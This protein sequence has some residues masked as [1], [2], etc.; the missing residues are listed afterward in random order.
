MRLVWIHPISTE[1]IGKIVARKINLKDCQQDEIMSKRPQRP[2]KQLGEQWSSV[3]HGIFGRSRC[4]VRNIKK[5]LGLAQQGTWR[6]SD[7]SCKNSKLPCCSVILAHSIRILHCI[8]WINR[9]MGLASYDEML[10]VL[11][12]PPFTSVGE[13]MNVFLWSAIP[14]I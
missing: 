4:D 6:D 8:K 5:S 3:K 11:A 2:G 1:T 12:G 13:W 7:N 9:K 14:G 10:L